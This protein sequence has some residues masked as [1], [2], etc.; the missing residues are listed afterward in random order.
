MMGFL[1]F[2]SKREGR[3]GHKFCCFFNSEGG[4]PSFIRCERVAIFLFLCFTHVYES[5]CLGEYEGECFFFFFEEK[6]FYC[7]FFIWERE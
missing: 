4:V 1:F 2:L 6:V 7:F 3:G 5:M